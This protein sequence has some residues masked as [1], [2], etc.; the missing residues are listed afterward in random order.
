MFEIDKSQPVMVT[1]ATGYVA[2]WLVKRLLEE[3][4]RVHATVRNP[5]DKDRLRYLDAAAAE[6]PGTLTFFKADL[7]DQGSFDEAMA[8]CAVVFHT[9]SPFTSKIQDPERDL[10]RPALE[11]TRNVLEAVNRT[12]SVRRVV[13]TSSCA[14]IYGDNLDLKEKGLAALDESV[15][16]TSSSLKHQAYSYSKTVAE[17]AA[18]AL[19]KQ[20]ERWQL[21][22]VNPSLVMGPGISPFATSESF[23]LMRQLGDGTMKA[24]VPDWPIGVV[25]VRDLAEAHLR[26]AFLPD[27]EGRH[28]ISG[29]DTSFM[30]MAKVLAP[31]FGK[32]FPLPRNTLP[33]WLVWLA[34]PL[35]NKAMTRAMVSRNVGHPWHADNSKSVQALGMHYRPLAET[36]E[37]FFVQ[38]RDS[39]QFKK[40]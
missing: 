39:G 13:L 1:G 17:Q 34:G 2:G 30:G 4:L 5:A 9:A 40:A 23:S 28:I 10:V 36:L 33:K 27:A 18:W 19:A 37:D 35:T 29:H 26:A 31:R 32:D 38:M 7:L 21:V 6:A 22:V 15:W 25:D 16:N 3:G 12:A 14:A 11:G 24:G 20:Q 8:G